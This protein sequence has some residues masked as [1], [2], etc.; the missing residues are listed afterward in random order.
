MTIILLIRHGEND[1]VGKSLAGRLLGVHLNDRGRQQAEAIAEQLSKAPIKALYSSPLERAMETAQPLA[2][3]LGM[4]IQI[5]PG[6][7]EVDYGEW[8]GK[9][10]Q[11]L[12]R[13]KLWKTVQTNPAEVRFP[14]GESLQEAQQRGC[15]EIEILANSHQ[16][17]DVIACV[18]HSDIIRLCA[19]HFLG[20]KL[21]DFQRLSISTAS[22]TVFQFHEKRVRLLH[23]NQV[24]TFD[25]PQGERKKRRKGI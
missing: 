25:L 1:L 10:F 14:G 11:Q 21:N 20:M 9:T 19:A 22:M 17:K 12:K 24:F 6:L 13:L 15:D 3:R 4:D 18:T 23:L 2:E 7:I 16:Q 5:K 8:E